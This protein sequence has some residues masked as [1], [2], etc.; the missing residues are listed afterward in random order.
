MDETGDRKFGWIAALASLSGVA[1]MVPSLIAL[2][3]TLI[4]LVAAIF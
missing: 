1:V 4:A 3:V 2:A